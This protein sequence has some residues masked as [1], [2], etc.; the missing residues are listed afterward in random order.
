MKLVLQR[1]SNANVV[2][3]GKE[4]AKISKGLLV[5]VGIGK[6]TNEEGMKF[7]AEKVMNLRIFQDDEGKM[8]LS[9]LDVKGE[10]L[11]VSQF[12]LY[13]DCR[14][15]RRPSYT[16]AASPDEAKKMYERF[17][18]ILKEI[19]PYKVE[20]GI[21]QAMMDVTLCNAGPVTI[22]LDGEELRKK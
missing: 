16:D 2:I 8:N 10:I 17:V 9:I 3:E 11:L 13:A 20:S 18:E 21:F 1:V 4:V 6:D 22:I 15:G 14:K 12:T 5:L 7:L 19:Y